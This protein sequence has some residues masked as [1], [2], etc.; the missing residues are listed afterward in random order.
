MLRIARSVPHAFDPFT[1]RSS[2]FQMSPTSLALEYIIVIFIEENVYYNFFANDLDYPNITIFL[3]MIHIIWSVV[4]W[5]CGLQMTWKIGRPGATVLFCEKIRPG[6]TNTVWAFFCK[7]SEKR[8]AWCDSHCVT[9]FFLKGPAKRTAL[10]D[11]SL[12]QMFWNF[13]MC[14][15]L[16]KN[17]LCIPHICY[18]FY[19]SKIF[20]E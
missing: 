2:S 14:W 12:L 17:V 6:V 8:T 4:S 19:T 3:Q 1:A 9:V 5:Q 15:P 11:S 13:W 7:W 16:A 18:F 20:G 10:C